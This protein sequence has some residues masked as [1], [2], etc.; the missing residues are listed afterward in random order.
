M[1]PK[2]T[3]YKYSLSKFKP[4]TNYVN[5]KCYDSKCER[6]NINKSK[7]KTKK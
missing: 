2:K 5:Y 1:R 3:I 4:N 6:T 7:Y